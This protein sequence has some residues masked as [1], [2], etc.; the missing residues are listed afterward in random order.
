[1][2]PRPLLRYKNRLRVGHAQRCRPGGSEMVTNGARA[3]AGSSSGARPEE[4]SDLVLNGLRPDKG[5]QWVQPKPASLVLVLDWRSTLPFL[6]T[7]MDRLRHSFCR[8]NRPFLDLPDCPVL[9]AARGGSIPQSQKDTR[10]LLVGYGV[11]S[12]KRWYLFRPLVYS[13]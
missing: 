7:N 12:N 3:P 13:A 11:D 1:M 4:A 2:N 9:A 5:Y 10:A 8:V 6:R